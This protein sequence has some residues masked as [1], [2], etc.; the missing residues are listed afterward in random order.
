MLRPSPRRDLL[1][2]KPDRALLSPARMAIGAGRDCFVVVRGCPLGTGKDRCEWHAG[3]TADEDDV[4]TRSRCWL[5]R[6]RR[7]RPVLGDHCLV[8]KSL[9]GSR[10][11]PGLARSLAQLVRGWRL[12]PVGRPT[13]HSVPRR[14]AF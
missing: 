5:H 13:R 10:S 6:D 12:Q 14:T 1:L 2:P 9:E 8:A 4:G 7:V 3:G 11:R